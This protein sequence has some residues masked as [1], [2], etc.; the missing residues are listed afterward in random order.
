[1][2]TSISTK[3]GYRT[4]DE[5]HRLMQLDAKVLQ[6]ILLFSESESMLLHEKG[7]ECIKQEN[8]SYYFILLHNLKSET[9]KGSLVWAS[10]KH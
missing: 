3:H 9:L 4:F 1:M 2:H 6:L 7:Y 5:A 8:R 10:Y